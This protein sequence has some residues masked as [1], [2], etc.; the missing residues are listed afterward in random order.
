MERQEELVIIKYLVSE[1]SVLVQ[2]LQQQ[3]A[4]CPQSTQIQDKC[5]ANLQPSI[6]PVDPQII[7][8]V[9]ELLVASVV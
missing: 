2:I 1:T 5:S 3:A 7:M 4:L 9:K 6:S 8:E